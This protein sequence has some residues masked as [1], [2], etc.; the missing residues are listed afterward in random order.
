MKQA[1]LYEQI[2]KEIRNKIQSV[3]FKQGDKIPSEKELSEK[4]HVSRITSKKAV[5]MLAEAGMVIRMPGKGT[6][7]T[8]SEERRVKEKETETKEEKVSERVIGVILD[9]FGP[10]FGC[11]MLG[12]IEAEC[13]RQGCEMVFHCSYGSIEEETKAIDNLLTLGVAGILI[14]CVHDENYNSRIL[15]LVVERFPVVTLDR[16]MKGIPV[17]FV[18]TDNEAAARELT[19][20]LL[21]DGYR[22][23][24]FAKPYAA[25]TP[26]IQERMT[27]FRMAFHDYGIVPDE[28]IWMTDLKATLPRHYS[29]EQVEKDM[30]K[31]VRF[32]KD[33]P[34]IEAFVAVEYSIARIIYR[35]LW[36]LG[37]HKK[38]PVFCFDSSDNIMNEAMFTHVKQ[39]EEKIGQLGVRILMDEI[40]GKKEK[41]HVLVPYQI[42]EATEVGWD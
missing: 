31:V 30:G 36:Q 38:C 17:S 40:N 4:Y 16:Q 32:V 7:V 39:S 22:K 13:H 42:V 8:G 27:G 26:T 24:C 6:F 37:L 3:E 2:Y 29:E 20:C 41:Q 10:S 25:E 12:G 34:Q 35:C 18:G 11:Q 21:E 9:G 19:A 14:M 5:D 1:P 33:H 23:I 15:Q 28:E